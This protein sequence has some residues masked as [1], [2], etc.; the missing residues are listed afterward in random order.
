MKKTM[1]PLPPKMKYIHDT[2]ETYDYRAEFQHYIKKALK[3]QREKG[4]SECL[5]YSPMIIKRRAKAAE[6]LLPDFV[7]R[8][9]DEFADPFYISQLFT[10]LNSLPIGSLNQL[11][12][13]QHLLLAA[14]IWILDQVTETGKWQSRLA[15]LLPQNEDLLDEI[16]IPDVWHPRYEFD[17]ILSVVYI[18]WQRYGEPEPDGKDSDLQRLIIN[19]ELAKG[20]IQAS[21]NFTALISMIPEE[22]IKNAVDHYTDVA[23]AW[24]DH[25]VSALKPT[26]EELQRITI[27]D[28]IVVD[29]YNEVRE[30]LIKVEQ[31]VI[32]QPKKKPVINPLLAAPPIMSQPFSRSDIK[33]SSL[34]LRSELDSYGF[35]DESI[36]KMM[37][38]PMAHAIFDIVGKMD[39][40]RNR[41]IE[42]AEEYNDVDS[43]ILYNLFRA[44]RNGTIEGMEQLEGDIDPYE[45]CFA[46]LML[47]EGESDFPWL[48]GLNVG[49]LSEVTSRFPWAYREY[50]EFEDDIWFP[51][52]EQMSLLAPEIKDAGLWYVQKY[53][54]KD[55]TTM[56]SMAQILYEETGCLL[57]RDLGKY[58]PIKK[59]LRKYGLSAKDTNTMLL[60]MATLGQAR[61]QM[62]T[63]IID[64]WGEPSLPEDEE[65]AET[66]VEPEK[67][68]PEEIKRL[69]AALHEAERSTRDA[70][71]DL[72]TI[73]ETSAREHRELADL[74]SLI[75]SLQQD[76]PA[77]GNDEVDESRF[78][79]EVQR[80][81]LVF[82][83]HETWLK[84]IKP[85]LTGNVRFIDKDLIFDTGIIRH[86]D[87]IWIQTNALSHSQ[88]GRI[89][90]TARIF[91]K[92]IRYFSN[93]SA[94]KCAEQL[95]D[96]DHS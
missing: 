60:M 74:R 6:T 54:V 35:S 63:P 67:T 65:P 86:A 37:D 55:D 81:T 38:D 57:P 4:N 92:P 66:P 2:R 3:I 78:P 34:A 49:M 96:A 56:L 18:L 16:D 84:A 69:R 64:V 61:R 77:D 71:K 27:E 15:P 5:D 62:I 8:Y 23:I 50:S 11:E 68:D 72:A 59:R 32:K 75:F 13:S 14:A 52:E 20:K 26:I 51:D 91:K 24:F 10:Q 87:M 40:L 44:G 58:E 79:Y 22:K 93:A 30:Q 53:H 80:E 83:G 28:S 76:H 39:S 89:T 82:G 88:Y 41:S 95:M 19:S 33:L 9:E 12:D 36:D 73:K 1:P 25:L 45:M 47:I 70:K 21:E 17:L 29:K 94:A 31:T 85:M 48:C 7:K 43:K 42:L 46:L 90:D